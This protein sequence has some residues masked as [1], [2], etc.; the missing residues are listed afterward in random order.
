MVKSGM[1]FL[2]K[3][4]N[5]AKYSLLFALHQWLTMGFNDLTIAEK[6]DVGSADEND[7]EPEMPLLGCEAAGITMKGGGR[8]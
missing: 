2:A 5:S 8:A 1:N 7:G 4:S 6:D 3:S